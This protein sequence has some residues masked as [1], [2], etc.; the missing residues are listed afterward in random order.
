MT[1]E[2]TGMTRDQVYEMSLPDIE[3]TIK[4][5][6]RQY[7]GEY[8]EHFQN[9]FPMFVYA[10]ERW[11][12]QAGNFFTWLRF[13]IWKQ[14]LEMARQKARRAGRPRLK[15]MK[16]DAAAY[17]HNLERREARQST[18]LVDLIDELSDD[19]QT[20]LQL[21][22]GDITTLRNE[23]RKVR[24]GDRTYLKVVKDYLLGYGWSRNRI[25]NAYTEIKGVI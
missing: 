10:W 18:Y 25:K 6:I 11:D 15:Q 8:E 21:F 9:A 7:G 22:L 5:H 3:K 14:L 23:A 2:I 16:E 4:H 17:I 1:K 19:G 13:I 24:G 12:D 20:V